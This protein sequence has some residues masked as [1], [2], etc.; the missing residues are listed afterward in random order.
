MH[1]TKLFRKRLWREGRG[2]AFQKRR[3]QIYRDPENDIA[4]TNT[5][6]I[7]AR[8]FGFHSK[9]DEIER[10]ERYMVEQRRKNMREQIREEQ[11]EICRER[12]QEAAKSAPDVNSLDLP[13]DIA[14]V[15]SH[16]AMLTASSEEVVLRES[17]FAGAPSRGAIGMLQYYCNNKRDFYKTVLS[18]LTR[19][20]A[21]APDERELED[22]LRDAKEIEAML[23]Q[24]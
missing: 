10:Y 6:M 12:D 22:D 14:W 24:I 19:K 8:E 9:H 3:R 20:D 15:Y 13:P 1:W 23:A 17:D 5:F 11:E 21:A 7:A 2:C 18:H 4:W 16:P